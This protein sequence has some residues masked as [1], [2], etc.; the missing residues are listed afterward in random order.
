MTTIDTVRLSGGALGSETMLVRCD[1]TQAS[2]PV[3]VDYCTG[4]GW[5]STQWQ[6]ADCRHTL[7]GLIELATRLAALAVEV[8]HEDFDCN[9]EE[10][11]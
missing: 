9:V 11:D 3:Q 7:V 6:C 10:V 8:R 1:L 2:A 4:D 5:E